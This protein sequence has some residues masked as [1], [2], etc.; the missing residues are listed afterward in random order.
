MIKFSGIKE[1]C[2]YVRDLE[3]ARTFYVDRLGLTLI[4]YVHGKH[5]FLRAGHSVL[6][7]FNPEDSKTKKSPPAH[8]GGGHQHFAF[9]VKDVDYDSAKKMITSK[10]IEIIDEITWPSGR[11]SFIFM[12]PKKMFLK[13]FLKQEYG[14]NLI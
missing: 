10:S 11:Q 2:I 3:V 14:T 7:I 5:L 1:T 8:F 6:L 13:L 4:N 9:E 12:I